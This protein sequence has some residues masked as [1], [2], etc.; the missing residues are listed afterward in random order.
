SPGKEPLVRSLHSIRGL[1]PALVVLSY[2]TVAGFPA[3]ATAAS[4]EWSRVSLTNPFAADAVRW[5]LNG[6][7]RQLDKA[8]CQSLFVD[9]QD[10]EGRPLQ[11]R[12]GEL[13]QTASEYLGLVVFRDGTAEKRC[14]DARVLAFTS[15][16]SRVVYVCEKMFE[17]MWR[18][19]AHFAQAV[20][21]HEALHTLGLGEN[22]PTSG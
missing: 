4:R 15:P 8:L 22:P 9:F 13:D 10:K 2:L 5:S 12:L 18:Q 3:A 17:Q 21:I 14:G 1:A 7:S 16:G 19:D 6:A 11:A 20:L